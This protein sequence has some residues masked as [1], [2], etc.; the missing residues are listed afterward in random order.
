MFSLLT[1]KVEGIAREGWDWFREEV[2]SLSEFLELGEKR[3]RL[4]LPLNEESFSML[5]FA[6]S[7]FV[8]SCRA[9]ISNVLIES[10][11]FQ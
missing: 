5:A 11:R 8:E 2:F 7:F 4:L 6:D 3:E 10:D 9:F 1:L